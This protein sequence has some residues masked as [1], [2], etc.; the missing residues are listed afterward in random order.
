MG[1]INLKLAL[2]GLKIFFV[3][4]VPIYADEI[5]IHK[6]KVI[7]INGVG[8]SKRTADI[9]RDRI[10]QLLDGEL[11]SRFEKVEYETFYNSSYSNYFLGKLGAIFDFPETIL[12]SIILDTRM[13]RQGLMGYY[14]RNLNH[15][16]DRLQVLI[17]EGWKIL[18]ITH[19]QGGLFANQLAA[20]NKKKNN[21]QIA[22]LQLATPSA[23]LGFKNSDY[24][25][26]ANDVILR[27]PFSLRSNLPGVKTMSEY[28]GNEGKI[29]HNVLGIYLSFRYKFYQAVLLEKTGR[30]INELEECT[31]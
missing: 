20:L 30:L 14:N 12:Q 10:K 23:Y 18:I 4:S 24:M 13:P 26:N 27:V 11:T 28:M 2:I 16:N 7:Y 21:C 29:F 17:K 19:S 3:F 22:N 5:Q 31:E 6:L 8:T 1:K 25:T 9:T 15:M